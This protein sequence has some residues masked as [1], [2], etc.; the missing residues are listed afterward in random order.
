MIALEK[1]PSECQEVRSEHHN[2]IALETRLYSASTFKTLG[3]YYLV[4]SSLK[5]RKKIVDTM[6]KRMKA[7]VL[8]LDQ[9]HRY[10]V[11]FHPD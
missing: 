1:S 2:Y 5:R 11:A 10:V 4:V 8:F 7:L 3:R 9:R 6:R